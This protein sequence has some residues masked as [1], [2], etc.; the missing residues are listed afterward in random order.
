MRIIYPNCVIP[1]PERK[2]N[3]HTRYVAD[4]LGDLLDSGTQALSPHDIPFE[5]VRAGTIAPSCSTG[6]AP[7]ITL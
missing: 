5:R 2:T 4:R 1:T 6:A 7:D 3:R